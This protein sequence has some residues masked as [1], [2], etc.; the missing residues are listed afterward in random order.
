MQ[1]LW[2]G[3]AG[4]GKQNAHDAWRW[5]LFAPDEGKMAKWRVYQSI[6]EHFSSIYPLTWGQNHLILYK[7]EQLEPERG[8]KAAMERLGECYTVHG[9]GGFDACLAVQEKLANYGL[10]SYTRADPDPPKWRFFFETNL[11]PEK[12]S[13]LLGKYVERYDIKFA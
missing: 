10:C 9:K 8:A 7:N 3:R 2:L 13:E 6:L 11:K 1:A 12:T 5:P 4:S